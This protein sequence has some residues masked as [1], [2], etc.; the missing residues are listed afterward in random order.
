[1][2]VSD[3][4]Y[5]KIKDENEKLLEVLKDIQKRLNLMWGNNPEAYE[6]YFEGHKVD[7][8]IKRVLSSDD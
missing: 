3:A 4:M 5:Y 6:F 1:M 8:A 2:S 7:E